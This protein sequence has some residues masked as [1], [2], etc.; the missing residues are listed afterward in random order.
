MAKVPETPMSAEP[1]LP[2]RGTLAALRRAAATCRGCPLHA[3]ATQTVFG[4]GRKGARVLFVGEQPGNE[5]D[6][7]G[8]P[9]VGPAGR[10]LDEGLGLA[11]IDRAQ[12][13]VTNAVKH[14]KWVP[15]GKRR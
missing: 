9:F 3:R 11:G 13:Y 5:E 2:E 7:A 1:F 4:A 12:A 8:E 14:F 6:L 15:R 10:V